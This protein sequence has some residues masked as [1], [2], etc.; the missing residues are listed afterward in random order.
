MHNQIIGDGERQ[1]EESGKM[2]IQALTEMV[3]IRQQLTDQC[4]DLI[5][6][7]LQNSG[8]KNA[9]PEQ[10]ISPEEAEAIFL[11]PGFWGDLID[12]GEV[13]GITVL[14]IKKTA[15]NHPV[16]RQVIELLNQNPLTSNAEAFNILSD[17]RS[18][19]NKLMTRHR[20]LFT[21]FIE[22]FEKKIHDTLPPPP[23]NNNAKND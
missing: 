2:D 3:K 5:F 9:S 23:P 6:S 10:K 20:P 18:R 14:K 19:L 17:V 22:Y 11:Q 21:Q 4:C 13:N 12:I 15:P 1:D 16:F 7:A 8:N